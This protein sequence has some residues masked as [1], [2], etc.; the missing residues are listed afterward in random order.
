MSTE[1][2]Q[3]TELERL[4]EKLNAAMAEEQ[5]AQ[6]KHDKLLIAQLELT[7]LVAESESRLEQ[8]ASKKATL[9]AQATDLAKRNGKGR[10]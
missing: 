6:V 1:T 3:R 7:A 10:K 5:K 9:Q 8:L 4:K 2:A